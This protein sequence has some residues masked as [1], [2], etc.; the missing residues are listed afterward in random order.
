MLSASEPWTKPA[1]AFLRNRRE[2]SESALAPGDEEHGEVPSDDEREVQEVGGDR[3][4]T[5]G[6][7][8]ASGSQG[9]KPFTV[10]RQHSYKWDK[11]QYLRVADFF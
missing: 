7:R 11:Y 10:L 6:E 1:G 8:R 3:S 2:G 4:T 5:C 9:R